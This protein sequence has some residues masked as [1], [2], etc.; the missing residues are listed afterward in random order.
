MS[1]EENEGFVNMDP[2]V[3]LFDV[4]G[5]NDPKGHTTNAQSWFFKILSGIHT[6]KLSPFLP[7]GQD[8]PYF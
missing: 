8:G 1:Y 3:Y 2:M 6:F 5:Q 4:C 7:F